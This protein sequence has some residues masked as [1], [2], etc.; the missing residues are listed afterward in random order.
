M[1]SFLFHIYQVVS[2]SSLNLIQ[3]QRKNSLFG[4]APALKSVTSLIKFQI[5][6]LHFSRRSFSIKCPFLLHRL[7]KLTFSEF[8]TCGV[9]FDIWIWFISKKVQKCKCFS[10]TN[11]RMGFFLF[12][13]RRIPNDK[14][15]ISRLDDSKYSYIFWGHFEA[16]SVFQASIKKL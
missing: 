12:C 16:I 1:R 14:T 5:V 11:T 8:N 7:S 13:R 3:L 10:K 15:R 2:A 9:N 6:V 4:G